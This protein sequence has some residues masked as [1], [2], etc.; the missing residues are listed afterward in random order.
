MVYIL[1]MFL[2]ILKSRTIPGKEGEG[3]CVPHG[4]SFTGIVNS[5]TTKLYFNASILHKK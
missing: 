1:V 4:L 5:I 3:A 2:K